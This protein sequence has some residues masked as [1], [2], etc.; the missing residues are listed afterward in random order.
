MQRLRNRDVPPGRLVLRLRG[1]GGKWHRG[2][3]CRPRSPCR[4]PG[5][6]SDGPR[7]RLTPPRPAPASRRRYR[8]ATGALNS[9]PGRTN[10]VRKIS[11]KRKRGIA[12]ILFPKTFT[13]F[14][15]N[16]FRHISLS[17]S[18]ARIPFS[19]ASWF[20]RRMERG[21]TVGCC[22]YHYLI[23]IHRTKIVMNSKIINFTFFRGAL[24][25]LG[26]LVFLTACQSDPAP[27]SNTTIS[28][29]VPRSSRS[30]SAAS[31]ASS[32]SQGS[33]ST[34]KP[35]GSGSSAPAPSYKAPQGS[36]TTMPQGSGTSVP[37]GSGSR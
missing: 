19:P 4:H 27:E 33:G 21:G 14:I 3:R 1:Q 31:T 8:E 15:G 26:G 20:P 23:P 30:S 16:R 7:P 10:G 34:T 28:D 22:C 13:K 18:A 37:Q 6:S 9:E 36:G 2:F 12:G 29:P 17:L 5:L 35:Q 11:S 32:S 25:V 24:A